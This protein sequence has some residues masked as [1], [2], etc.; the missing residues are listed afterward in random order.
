MTTEQQ[1]FPAEIQDYFQQMLLQQTGFVFNDI[2]TPIS[3]DEPA[4]EYLKGNGVYNQIKTARM[5]DDPNLPQGDWQHNL[6][7]ADWQEVSDVALKALTEKSKDIQLGIW[8]IEAQVNR[9]GFAGIAPAIYLLAQLIDEYW[10]DIHP[11]IVDDDE[12]YRTNLIAWLNEKLQPSIRQINITASRS[13]NQYCWADWEMAIHMEQLPDDNK[14]QTTEYIQ[15]QTIIQSINATPM[16]FYQHAHMQLGDAIS[17]LTILGQLLD[18]KCTGEAPS[19]SGL[20]QLLNEI[21][22]TLASLVQ[23]RG[24]LAANSQQQGESN[25]ES[26]EV[27]EQDSPA[28]PPSNGGNDNLTSRESAY[29][30]LAQ[31]AEY[32]MKDDPHSPVPY[33]IF[34]AIEWGNLN[35]AEL[36]Q[37][38][39]VQYQGQ[40]NIFE[41]LGLEINK[42]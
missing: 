12:E 38:L 35:T 4:G 23:H 27:T 7:V 2:M 17:S 11:Q 22:E 41:I 34:K 30:Q 13:E 26:D 8:V 29:R 16:E 10:Q 31:A 14:R 1:T 5:Q 21:R 33:L 19:L 15:S 18:N 9:Y 39:F 32:L 24:S 25:I 3:A 37:E 40:L 42:S 36:Y 6:K 28:S 20:E